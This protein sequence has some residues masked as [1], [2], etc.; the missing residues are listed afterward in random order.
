[1]SAKPKPDASKGSSDASKR[2]AMPFEPKSTQSEKK[3]EKKSSKLETKAASASGKSNLKSSQKSKSK[4][5]SEGIPEVV[6][7]RMVPSE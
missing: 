2:K 4:A 3:S 6:S 1:M 7:R 5:R